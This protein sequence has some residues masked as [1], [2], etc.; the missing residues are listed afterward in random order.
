[1]TQRSK[2]PDAQKVNLTSSLSKIE[3]LID[4]LEHQ[5]TSLEESL[6]AFES[7]IKLVQ[8][9]QN[10]LA[11]AEQKV[12]ALLEDNGALTIH[13]FSEEDTDQ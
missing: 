12:N 4:T 6:L 5:D 3:A 9:A 1:M 10:Q 2:V 11:S 8:G 13:E 7:G